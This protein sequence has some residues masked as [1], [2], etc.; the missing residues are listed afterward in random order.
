MKKNTNK[1]RTLYQD[2]LLSLKAD[3]ALL[4]SSGFGLILCLTDTDDKWWAI[5]I[6]CL[7]LIFLIYSF[8]TWASPKKGGL[9]PDMIDE[10]AQESLNKADEYTKATLILIGFIS[11]VVL[12]IINFKATL[13]LDPLIIA[14]VFFVMVSFVSGLHNFFFLMIERKYS[15][16]EEGE[17]E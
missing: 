14:D 10:M 8:G 7:L 5:I 6:R 1:T 4:L 16:P 13:K 15:I 12:S 3:I 2:R 9:R 11:I 17:E